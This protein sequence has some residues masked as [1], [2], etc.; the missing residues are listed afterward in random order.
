MAVLPNDQTMYATT[1][2]A[3]GRVNPN[4]GNVNSAPMNFATGG[5]QNMGWGANPGHPMGYGMSSPGMQNPRLAGFGGFQSPYNA[6]QMTM[7]PRM[8]ALRRM[9]MGMG[10]A[11]VP[12]GQMMQSFQGSINPQGQQYTGNRMIGGGSINPNMLVQQRRGILPTGM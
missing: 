1:M 8:V 7:D 5:G 12:N 11:Q 4:R 3:I 10:N 2:P 9:Q 6:Q